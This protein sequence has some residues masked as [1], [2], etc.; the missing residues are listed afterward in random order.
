[1]L[2]QV[3]VTLGQ[4]KEETMFL[5]IIALG[6]IPLATPIVSA[7]DTFPSSVGGHATDV[8]TGDEQQR[9]LQQKCAEMDRL[10]REIARL[11]AASGTAQQII[12][13]VQ[14]MEVSLTK[15]RQM[16]VDTE[17]FANGDVGGQSIRKLVDELS[18]SDEPPVGKSANKAELNDILL[19]VDGLRKNGLA[20]V[21]SE[22]SL[23]AVAGQPASVHSGGK[24]PLPTNDETK[25]AV[26]FQTFG[27]E[28]EVEA[29]PIG[30]N[31][32]RLAVNAKVSEVDASR[33]ID[34]N[35]VRIPGLKVRH[36]DTAVELPFGQ[37][38]MLTG[39]LE[40][41]TESRQ[42]EDGQIEKVVVDMGLIVVVTPQLVTPIEAPVANANRETKSR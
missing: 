40:R 6:L 3:A 12:V 16:G 29:L 39:L 30:D 35:G 26:E 15:L 14:M 13:K 11:R 37:T 41:R 22:P 33:A 2:R 7:K 25:S 10:Q 8:A 24:F 5:R 19:F 20:K 36:C 21:L 9:L 23:V 32:V 18:G 28:L 34:V 17:W 38:A 1:M 4:G 27:T 42:M 31:R